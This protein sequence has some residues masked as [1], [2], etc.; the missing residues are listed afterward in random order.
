MR[1]IEH[2]AELSGLLDGAFSGINILFGEEGT[3]AISNGAMVSA[4]YYKDGK[5]AGTLGVVGPMRLD[6]RKVI[7][8]IEYLSRKVTKLLSEDDT[9]LQ[10]ESEEDDKHDE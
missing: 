2:K 10:I 4:S 5:P 6:Y 8:Y 7:P 3:F 1:F 9:A